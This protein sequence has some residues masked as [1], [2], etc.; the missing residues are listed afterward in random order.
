MMHI[1][2]FYKFFC[3]HKIYTLPE[4]Y[5][6]PLKMDGWKTTFLPFGVPSAY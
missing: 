1:A 3:M 2:Y 4:T 5:I 6:S